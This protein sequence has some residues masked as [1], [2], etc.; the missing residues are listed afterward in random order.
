MRHG[1]LKAISRA[2]P[3]PP[4]TKYLWRR[5]DVKPYDLLPA[6]PVIYDIGAQEARGHYAFGSPP[7]G[8]RLVDRFLR[9]DFEHLD[10]LVRAFDIRFGFSAGVLE[11]LQFGTI[12]EVTYGCKWNFASRQQ[13][14]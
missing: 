5:F 6:K 13:N 1:I 14:C 2:L 7:P 3:S 4:S 8:A 11:T 10:R 12:F 9:G